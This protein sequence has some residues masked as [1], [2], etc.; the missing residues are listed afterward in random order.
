MPRTKLT[1]GRV[2]IVNV[3]SA[4]T[5]YKEKYY[6]AM[7]RLMRDAAVVFV[8]SAVDHVHVDTGM[9]AAS[10]EPM[11]RRARTSILSKISPKRSR[12]GGMTMTGR[13]VP[14]KIRS[15]FEGIRAGQSAFK[16][17][18]GNVDRPYMSFRFQIKVWQYWYWEPEW[19]SLNEASI[20]AEIFIDN[21]YIKYL[22]EGLNKVFKYGSPNVNY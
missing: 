17:N 2:S 8:N 19:Q 13:Y 12:F 10:L 4:I 21:N 7:K 5:N 22:P 20:D 1:Y 3:K 16:F 18:V 14:K 6:Q 9:S 11:A 15:V